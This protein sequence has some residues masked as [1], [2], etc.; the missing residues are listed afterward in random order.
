MGEEIGSEMALRTFGHLVSL[1]SNFC[2]L[3]YDICSSKLNMALFPHFYHSCLVLLLLLF[4]LFR[5][6]EFAFSPSLS[7]VMVSPHWGE[8][9]PW[10]WLSFLCPTLVWTSW[11][12]S[13]SSPTMPTLRCHTTPSLPW[14]WWAAVSPGFNT[15][16]SRGF[17]SILVLRISVSRHKQRPSGGHAEAAGAVPRQRPEQPLHGPTGSGARRHNRLVWGKGVKVFWSQYKLSVCA[18]AGPDSPG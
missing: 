2:C 6:H 8:Q 4:I 15:P 5:Q 11:T 16:V 17:V 10:P 7:C 13:A 18:S 3:F 9:C 12:P 1:S 14:A